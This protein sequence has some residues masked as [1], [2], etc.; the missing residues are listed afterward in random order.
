MRI[1][2]MWLAALATL[3]VLAGAARAE[4]ALRIVNPDEALLS[5]GP[6]T[7]RIRFASGSGAIPAGARLDLRLRPYGLDG[8]PEPETRTIAAN[9]VAAAGARAVD[10]AVDVPSVGLYRIEARLVSSAGRVIASRESSLA[11]LPKRTRPNP[12]DF[13]IGI[14]LDQ[15]DHQPEFL[16]PLVQRAGFSWV[17]GELSWDGVEQK[18]GQFRFPAQFDRSVDMAA[19]MGI[20]TLILLDYGNPAVYPRLFKEK[21]SFPMTP[22]ARARFADYVRAVVNRYPAVN[23]WEV[24]NEPHF[25][26]IGYDAYVALLK[27]VYP[28]IKAVPT[29]PGVVAC[30]GDWG[31]NP[32]DGCIAAIAKAGALRYKDGFSLHP[33]MYPAP[34]EVGYEGPG[35]PVRPV[36]MLTIWPYFEGFMNKHKSANGGRDLVLWV[37]E[38]GWPTAPVSPEQN[39]VTQA[40]NLLRT[41]LIA[42]RHGVAS[43]LCWHNLIDDGVDPLDKEMNFGLLRADLSP[44][45]G[46]IAATVLAST[47]ESL[48]WRRAWID[49]PDIKIQ[50]YGSGKPG[51][52]VIA[53]W[54][55]TGARAVNLLLP[56]GDYIQR[57]WDGRE[58]PVHIGSNGFRWELNTL[59]QYL[60]PQPAR[61]G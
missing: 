58:S 34:P 52:A 25:G 15:G 13:G 8:Q 46:F 53:G 40:A 48:P 61:G 31:G 2:G 39:E 26:E 24:W 16:L 17:R 32:V 56:A 10:V 20:T 1:A 33:Y 47:L 43:R 36:S 4:P 9:G 44:K 27:E 45:P 38:I 50:E 11:V 35:T 18:R 7:K 49:T 41:F 14:N 22:E 23:Y 42:R 54:A 5:S 3:A 29:S 60:I 37:S 19:R 12:R 55:V 28:I 51:D 59:P 21:E 30:G 57:S 6:G